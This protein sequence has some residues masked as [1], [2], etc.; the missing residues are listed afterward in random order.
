[1]ERDRKKDRIRGRREGGGRGSTVELIEN[2]FFGGGECHDINFP[3]P[4]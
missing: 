3:L 2:A 1:M 4:N